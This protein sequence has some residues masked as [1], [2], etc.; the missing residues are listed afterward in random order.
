MNYINAFPLLLAAIA[1]V[2]SQECAE[3]QPIC[4]SDEFSFT[5]E[6]GFSLLPSETTN[7]Y[8]CLEDQ[9][10]PT[11]YYMEIDSPGQILM[12]LAA[13]G[14]IDFILWGPYDSLSQAVASCGGGLVGSDEIACS[15]SGSSTEIINIPNAISGKFY[16]LLVTNYAEVVQ[17]VTLKKTGGSGTTSCEAI[18]NSFTEIPSTAP[19]K[20]PTKAPTKAPISPPTSP[21]TTCNDPTIN[22]PCMINEDC[23]CKKKCKGYSWIP[24]DRK[25]RERYEDC[26]MGLTVWNSGW[27][28][29]DGKE[30]VADANKHWGKC[31]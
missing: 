22:A 14:D 7:D 26:T 21:P 4:T 17:T 10:D 2:K 24:D 30:C 29:L 6:T 25:C 3:M 8:G 20:T 1:S 5:A 11:W 13:P 31:V 19:T 16:V 12:D 23:A 18:T 15:Y 28:C 9:P 27:V